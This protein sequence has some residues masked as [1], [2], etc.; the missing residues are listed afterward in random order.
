[1]LGNLPAD[2]R[3]TQIDT[4]L[5]DL[6]RFTAVVTAHECGHSVGLVQ[7][8][9]MPDGLYGGDTVNFPG[10]SDGHIRT[11]ALFPSGAINVMSP[12]LSYSLAINPAT[13]F[14]SLN[15]AYL[16]EQVFYGN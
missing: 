9:A 13:A 4:A 8:G 7:N 6:A 2:P 11:A 16:R 15:K 5:A 10:S 1:L 14:N 12:A 3:S